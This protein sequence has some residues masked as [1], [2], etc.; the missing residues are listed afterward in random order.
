M[1]EYVYALHDFIPEHEDEISFRAGE[2][3][4][5]VEK[6][7]LYGDGWWQGKNLAGKIGLFPQGYTTPSQP[8]PTLDGTP[9]ATHPP[10]S[11][12]PSLSQ[13]LSSSQSSSHQAQGG[14]QGQRT[15]T[16]SSSVPTLQRLDEESDGA[17]MAATLTDVQEAIE[18]LGIP[19]P[20]GDTRSF[21][22]ASSRESLRDTDVEDHHEGE[23]EWAQDARRLLAINA[24][25]E[26]ARRNRGEGEEE[27]HPP[28][29]L[30]MSDESEDDDD[31]HHS[32]R[33]HGPG[34]P[35]PTAI[36]DVG[37]GGARL[38]SIVEPDEEERSVRTLEPAHPADVQEEDEREGEEPTPHLPIS[39]IPPPSTSG[40]SSFPIPHP[41]QHQQQL[42]PNP[43]ALE[44]AETPIPSPPLS[45]PGQM[46]LSPP[47]PGQGNESAQAPA[48][49]TPSLAPSH[50]AVNGTSSSLTNGASSNGIANG[51]GFENGIKA[52]MIP[53][54]MSPE[55]TLIPSSSSPTKSHVPL[56]LQMIMG[57]SPP[58]SVKGS[59]SVVPTPNSFTSSFTGQGQSVPPSQSAPQFP[60]IPSTLSA[61]STS[62]PQPS[63]SQSISIPQSRPHPSE[64]T[65]D[66]VLTW[67]RQKGFEEAIVSKFLEN[68]ITGD[69]LLELDANL[70]KE[71]DIPAFGKRVRIANAIAD[72]RRPPSVNSFSDSQRNSAQLGM[73]QPTYGMGG[74]GGHQARQPSASYSNTSSGMYAPWTPAS[75]GMFSV[76]SAPSTGDLGM[77]IPSTMLA[78]IPS[79]NQGTYGQM[80]VGGMAGGMTSSPTY[81][82]MPSPSISIGQGQGEEEFADVSGS[83]TGTG[84]ATGEDGDEKIPSAPSI[85]LGLGTPNGKVKGKPAQLSLSPSDGNIGRKKAKGGRG[86]VEYVASSEAA[87]PVDRGV[88]S[89]SEADPASISKKSRRRHFGLSTDSGSSK[90]NV[91]RRVSSKDLSSS[92]TSATTAG[93]AT[94]ATSVPGS[95]ALT[96]K[97]SV[98]GDGDGGS[99]KQGHGKAK[100][101]IDVSRPIDR[102]SFFGGALSKGRKPPPKY[103][104]TDDSHGGEKPQRSLSR[105]LGS[106]SSKKGSTTPQQTSPITPAS[107]INAPSRSQTASPSPSASA[108]TEL[109]ASA[110]AQAEY[111]E[112]S[113]PAVLRKRSI[114]SADTQRMVASASSNAVD[115]KAGQSILDQIGRPDH[116]GWMRKKGERYNSWKL[117]YFVLR[118]P[119]LYY[120]KSDSKAETKIKGYINTHGYK[121]LADENANPG[122]YGFR[123]VH[124][125]ERPHFFSSDEQ[126]VVREWMK[127]LMKATIGRDY[128]KPVISSCNIPTIP[129][130]VA[131][132]MNPAPRP[133]SPGARDATQKANRRENPNQLSS[134]DARILMG[135]PSSETAGTFPVSSPSPNS[136]NTGFGETAGY[137]VD[138]PPSVMRDQSGGTMMSESAYSPVSPVSSAVVPPPSR[139]SRDQR[140]SFGRVDAQELELLKWAN[141]YL[142]NNL[143][144]TEDTLSK[145][146]GLALF[147]LT[148][149][150]KGRASDP[151][152][153]DSMFPSGPSDERL[154]GLFKLFDLLLDE[155]VKMGSVS[156]NEVRQ[157]NKDKV[158][159]LLRALKG[160]E[161][162]RKAI[163]RSIGM[164]GVQAGPWMGVQA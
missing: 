146:A 95:P 118:G 154:E 108:P 30:E 99:T 22:F 105:Y 31:Y 123:I 70:L 139:P 159:Q 86:S 26:M 21:S 74:M 44:D 135:L 122:R 110:S 148:E 124:D 153:P 24:Q 4:E 67:L 164:G 121:V 144:L 10:S 58:G 141:G 92:V 107:A 96:N 63:T 18:Q 20:E 91:S 128:T 120:L 59:G 87:D 97:D 5:V 68:D 51:N 77:P 36:G 64:W 7:D 28:E 39:D 35:R 45:M 47:I 129:L 103:P 56:P 27:Y 66:Q 130:T 113:L 3:I 71:L 72:L 145:H 93:G 94:S 100:R 102:L 75:A 32:T 157:G 41:H 162:K 156:I 131:Q 29:H 149:G 151:P 134:R 137:Y 40:S 78:T 52:S 109:K 80:N 84:T 46:P 69:V 14:G 17:V 53:L 9:Q 112:I 101:S 48:F 49:P 158:M 163:A 133:P 23:G 115:L 60:S 25:R 136:T 2:R 73:P 89:D 42:H 57:A 111:K 125:S 55:P 15:P 88:M 161:E 142:P 13:A 8:G 126:M 138:P 76:E 43:E 104:P 117:R 160:W 140:P 132:A 50:P 6:D 62:P 152:V 85:G 65:V 114:P 79:A 119:H 37:A 143:Q 106:Q 1:P 90:G 61:Q 33:V 34:A 16:V 81:V 19:H 54:P 11:S 98:N 38:D 12:S 150:I 147:R 116:S 82:G 83:A 127:A 155:G